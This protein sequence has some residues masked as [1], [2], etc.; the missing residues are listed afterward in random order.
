MATSQIILYSTKID[1]ARNMVIE[2]LDSY[3]ANCPSTSTYDIMYVKPNLETNV[4]LPWPQSIG[5][6]PSNSTYAK[7]ITD[8]KPYYYFV[9]KAEWRAENVVGLTLALDTI[10][11]YWNDYHTQFTNRTH[12]T[13]QHKDR[14]LKNGAREI[15][16][17]D[18]G[19]TPVL[20]YAGH[21]VIGEYSP[22]W[23][24]IYRSDTT[25]ED[26][27]VSCYACSK[28]RYRIST[29]QIAPVVHWE[30]NQ[31]TAGYYY[32]LIPENDVPNPSVVVQYA[33]NPTYTVMASESKPVVKFYLNS[34]GY[35]EIRRYSRAGVADTGYPF[36]SSLSWINFTTSRRVYVTTKDSIQLSDILAGSVQ[37]V[38]AGSIGPLYLQSIDQLNRTDNQLIKVV[39]LGYAPFQVTVSQGNL[40]IPTGW[41]YSSGIGLLKLNSL[42]TEFLNPE[43]GTYDT[44]S[45]EYTLN[46]TVDVNASP[47]IYYESKLYNSNF[48][49]LKFAYDTESYVVKP[50]RIR[51]YSGL[52]YSTYPKFVISYKP[53]NGINSNCAFKFTHKEGSPVTSTYRDG[54]DY[55]GVLVSTRNNELPLYNNEYLNYLKYGKQ[56]A[57]RQ[58]SANV[59][60]TWLSTLLSIGGGVAAGAIV[61]SAPGAIIGGIVGAISGISTAITSTVKAIDSQQQKEW[62]LQHQ[63]TNVTGNSDLDLFKWY[64]DGKLHVFRREPTNKMKN[65]LFTLF[66]RGGYACDDYGVP[67]LNSRY[68][69]NFLQCTPS[70]N[71]LPIYQPFIDDIKKHYEAG[72]TIFH[73]RNGAWTLDYEKENW[74]SKLVSI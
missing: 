13:R 43:I 37:T 26:S 45:V 8:S 22:L 39:E 68:W 52:N 35:I 10:N 55:E 21:N 19:I 18:E 64:S 30:R 54:L 65:L 50:E 71:P 41:S 42:N 31:L 67:D 23:Y 6:V 69:F 72:V 15:D 17:F 40:Q 20:Q 70:F 24:L 16:D 57:D 11:T 25:A 46:F 63:A 51:T 61:G 53:S 32:Y 12:I 74:E 33:S 47:N 49:G 1:P 36:Q 60:A 3:L 27:T 62:E 66:F 59:G 58:T 56:Y 29:E 44:G 9:T 34:N 7:I 5:W 2:E 28:E 14:F 73:C 48:Y 38:Q 4:N